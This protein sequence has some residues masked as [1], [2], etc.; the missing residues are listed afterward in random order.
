MHGNPALGWWPGVVPGGRGIGRELFGFDQ[1][2][3]EGP[4]TALVHSSNTTTSW[5]SSD[6]V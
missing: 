3:G 6:L 2:I 5:I 1:A 4:N